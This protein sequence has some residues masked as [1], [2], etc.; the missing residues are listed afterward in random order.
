MQTDQIETQL[1]SNTSQQYF[2]NQEKKQH[3]YQVT[4]VKLDAFKRMLKTYFSSLA[5]LDNA[6]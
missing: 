2:N 3:L 5:I 1:R 4:S 6:R